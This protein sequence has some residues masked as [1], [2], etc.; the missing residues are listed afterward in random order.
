MMTPYPFIILDSGMSIADLGYL[1]GYLSENDPRSVKEQL[2]SG[3]RQGGGWRPL[4][5]FGLSPA[6]DYLL[7][8]PGD[9]PLRPWAQAALRGEM[10]L[11]YPGDWV[12]ILQQDGSFE[13]AR[14]D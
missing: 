13:V 7:L 6:P 1:P 2:H 14:M 4:E 8:Y 11:V 9:P 10:I 3:Y 12:L 5:K